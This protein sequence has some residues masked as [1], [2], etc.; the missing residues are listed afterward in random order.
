[1]YMIIP[2]EIHFHKTKRSEKSSRYIQIQINR[3]CPI[4]IRKKG[5]QVGATFNS[6]IIQMT[7]W[8][9]F[10]M[11]GNNLPRQVVMQIPS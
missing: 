11:V 9:L 1:M 6:E 10:S 3:F 2:Y 8:Q 7:S 5:F 4:L